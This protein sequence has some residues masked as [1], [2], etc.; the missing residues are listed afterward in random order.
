MPSR[1]PSAGHPPR[2]VDRLQ[3]VIIP[4]PP[5]VIKEDSASG[6]PVGGNFGRRSPGLVRGQKKL[7]TE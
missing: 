2:L 6:Q 5:A 4:P 1:S 7:H 3:T